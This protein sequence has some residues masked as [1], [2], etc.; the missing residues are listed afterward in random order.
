MTNYHVIGSCEAGELL[1]IS[2]SNTRVTMSQREFDEDRNLALLKPAETL[3][4]G[5]Q[6]ST[7]RD[8]PPGT[9]VSTWGYPFL[10]NGY[11]PLLSVGY[12]AGYRK[13]Q[14]GVN[15]AFNPGNSR[16]PLLV[17]QDNKVTA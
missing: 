4:G 16:G 5:L 14:K 1:V 8:P 7:D 13:V 2:S 6:L 11:Y 9:S 12:V 17:A 15:G 3:S 10:F